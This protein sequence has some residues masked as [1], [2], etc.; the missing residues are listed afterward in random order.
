MASFEMR[1][2][3]FSSSDLNMA[4]VRE[5]LRSGGTRSA[6]SGV[7]ENVMAVADAYTR[8][9]YGGSDHYRCDVVDRRTG[10]VAFVSTA[11]YKAMLAEHR[12]HVLSSLNH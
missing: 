4:G 3:P 9:R 8:G 6:L 10:A 7:G 5:V 2:R 1:F 11:S 12:A